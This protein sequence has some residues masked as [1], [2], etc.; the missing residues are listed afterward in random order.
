MAFMFENLEVY[1]KA[2]DL[3]DSIAELSDGFPRG[4]GFVV[5]QLNRAALSISM[6]LAEG[7]G[8]FYESGSPAFLHDRARVD[9]RMRAGARTCQTARTHRRNRSRRSEAETRSHRQND[10][11]PYQRPG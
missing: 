11:R 7:N 5:D 8:R 6:N 3:A 1:Q 10:Q 4:Y 2:V 9:P